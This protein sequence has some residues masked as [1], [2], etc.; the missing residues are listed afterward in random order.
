MT[1]IV[2]TKGNALVALDKVP[3][4]KTVSTNK[5]GFRRALMIG[6]AKLAFVVALFMT[7]FASWAHADCL[8]SGA[9]ESCGGGGGYGYYS[10]AWPTPQPYYGAVRG[11]GARPLYGRVR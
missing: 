2:F 8:E 1:A 5:L 7:G 4:Q 6:K 11:G 9:A 3:F 10:Q